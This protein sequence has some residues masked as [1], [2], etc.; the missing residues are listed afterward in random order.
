MLDGLARD[1]R[2]SLVGLFF[3][4]EGKSFLRL[5]PGVNVIKLFFF[6]AEDEA[7]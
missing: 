3:S 7:K 6:V 5:T 2:S 1:K 4:N